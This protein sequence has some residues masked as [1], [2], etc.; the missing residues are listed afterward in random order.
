MPRKNLKRERERI[1]DKNYIIFNNLQSL[2]LTNTPNILKTFFKG[3][4]FLF[5]F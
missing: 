4:A 5:D 3:F 1:L 2:T